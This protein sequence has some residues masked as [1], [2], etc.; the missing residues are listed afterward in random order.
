MQAVADAGRSGDEENSNNDSGHDAEESD[1]HEANDQNAPS[2]VEYR[3]DCERCQFTALAFA[4][5][6][7]S[8]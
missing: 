7:C 5:L 4:S 1:I 3:S 2:A 8:M 6:F